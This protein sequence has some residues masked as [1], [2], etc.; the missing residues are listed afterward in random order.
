MVGATGVEPARITPQDPKSCVSANSTTRPTGGERRQRSPRGKPLYLSFVS[1]A[2][3]FF[4]LARFG[5]ILTLKKQL[6]RRVFRCFCIFYA[7]GFQHSRGPAGSVRS[8][9]PFWRRKINGYINC[10]FGE[11][12]D[13]S[14]ICSTACNFQDMED[15]QVNSFIDD[16]KP[17][18]RGQSGKSDKTVK[19]L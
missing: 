3:M 10:Y 8:A 19:S 9:R 11:T 18:S 16:F 14:A 17:D 15:P 2:N 13:I 1:R 12:V 7:A 6:F 4:A 5:R